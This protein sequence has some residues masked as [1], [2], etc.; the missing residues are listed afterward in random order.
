MDQ[1]KERNKIENTVHKLLATS[2]SKFTH[3]NVTPDSYVIIF[4]QLLSSQPS[5]PLDHFLT[6]SNSPS[7]IHHRLWAALLCAQPQLSEYRDSCLNKSYGA[8]RLS[9]VQAFLA[10]SLNHG[11]PFPLQCNK[12]TGPGCRFLHSPSRLSPP[13]PCWFH[14]CSTPSTFPAKTSRNGGN[15]PSS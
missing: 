13:S 10:S 7:T 4:L 6:V 9:N 8:H 2:N 11:F 12:L 14:R 15:E 3:S 1:L 5:L